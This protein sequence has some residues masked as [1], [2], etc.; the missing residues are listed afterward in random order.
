MVHLVTF[1]AVALLNISVAQAGDGNGLRSHLLHL[2]SSEVFKLLERP[3]DSEPAAV[4][5]F[6]DS[7][8]DHIAN[9]RVELG[10]L[11][12][13][14]PS[15]PDKKGDPRPPTFAFVA[16]ATGGTLVSLT[17]PGA[18]VDPDDRLFL[19]R[20]VVSD[21]MSQQKFS[22]SIYED[23]ALDGQALKFVGIGARLA[24]RP[25]L[26][27]FGWGLRLQLFGSYHPEHGGT[28]YFAISGRSGDAP[29]EIEDAGPPPAA[30]AGLR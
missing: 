22:V 1:I 14:L 11:F 13:L 17:R 30:P 28:A 2:S 25:T 29:G 27:L 18:S 15:K 16:R 6:N 5:K 19:Q 26:K 3:D 10:R 9:D 24:A 20:T 4:K 7:V 21:I 8:A 12:T 23:H